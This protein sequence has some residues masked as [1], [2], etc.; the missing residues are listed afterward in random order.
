MAVPE[1]LATSNPQTTNPINS[2]RMEQQSPIMS[3]HHFPTPKPLFSFKF[4]V[5]QSIQPRLAPIKPL[6]SSTVVENN[7]M[8]LPRNPSYTQSSL[9]AANQSNDRPALESVTDSLKSSANGNTIGAWSPPASP[10]EASSVN[11]PGQYQN[12]LTNQY[13]PVN[14]TIQS[15][16]DIPTTS[17]SSQQ[18][19]ATTTVSYSSTKGKDQT[20]VA[21]DASLQ[22]T[23]KQLNIPQ[24]NTYS[25]NFPVYDDKTHT[26]AYKDQASSSPYPSI[27]NKQ[28]IYNK[29][30][31][32]PPHNYAPS[33]PVTDRQG[34]QMPQKQLPTAS[35]GKEGALS[36]S[37]LAKYGDQLNMEDLYWTGKSV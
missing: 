35:F 34:S 3:I 29:E 11:L 18:N 21:R 10:L 32:A 27:T 2:T 5:D 26:Y 13:T 16:N 33:L 31:I 28:S 1:L 36:D 19:A 24:Q 6:I 15:V 25:Q 8:Q 23:A 22:P 30:P 37:Y 20:E 9:I 12:K 7:S 4:N 17:S 14:D